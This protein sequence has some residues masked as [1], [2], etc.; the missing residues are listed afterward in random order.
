[1]VHSKVG[2]TNEEQMSLNNF[3][4]MAFRIKFNS[5]SVT[6]TTLLQ[7]KGLTSKSTESMLH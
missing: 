1:M 5:T 2:N 4:V 6:F 7:V 3:S